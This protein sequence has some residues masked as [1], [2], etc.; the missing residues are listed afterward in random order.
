[1][2][3]GKNSRFVF[4]MVSP[5][6]SN[7]PS[8]YRKAKITVPGEG[9]NAM[10]K[11]DLFKAWT[12]GNPDADLI[13]KIHGLLYNSF[14]KEIINGITYRCY[15]EF[16][17]WLDHLDDD[18]WLSSSNGYTK[19]KTCSIHHMVVTTQREYIRA[20][21]GRKDLIPHGIF[22]TVSK[23]SK[24]AER[25]RFKRLKT[26]ELMKIRSSTAFDYERYVKGWK[27]PKH[28][29]YGFE[30]IIIVD[31]AEACSLTSA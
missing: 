21:Y 22:L 14:T 13:R 18:T 31:A 7:V 25:K 3:S 28:L 1:M 26:S 12:Q 17:L 23:D 6:M 29:G 2:T 27:G 10:N 16:G 11:D 8:L 24:D 20:R 9:R 5:P 15:L 4:I 30:M 19:A